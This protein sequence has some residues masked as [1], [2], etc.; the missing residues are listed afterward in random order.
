LGTQSGR[1]L[2]TMANYGLVRL[3]RKPR[4]RIAPKVLHDQV[5]LELPLTQ[6]SHAA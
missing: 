3:G 2:K 4:A 5:E 1:T 6:K